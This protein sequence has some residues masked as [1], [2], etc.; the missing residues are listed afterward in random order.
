MKNIFIESVNSVIGLSDGQKGAVVSLYRTLFEDGAGHKPAYKKEEEKEDKKDDKKEEK[1]DDKKDD[2]KDGGKTDDA[3][4][5]WKRNRTPTNMTPVKK[6]DIKYIALHYTA[7]NSSS[8]GSACR[9]K[10]P[11]NCSADFIIDDSE[12]YQ[13]NPDLD[14]YFTWAVGV[15]DPQIKDK[16]VDEA[17]A[18][19][20]NDAASLYGN[21][22]NANTISIE[23]CS[24][25]NG[26]RPKNASPLDPNFY[27]TEATLGNTAKVV[28][29]LLSKYPG[30]K[31]IRHYDVTGKPCPGPWCRDE[32]GTQQYLSFV[33]RCNATPAPT[34][35]EYQDVDDSSFDKSQPS[36]PDFGRLFAPDK[37]KTTA[38]DAANATTENTLNAVI[39][40]VKTP[41]AKVLAGVISKINPNAS[42]NVV[43]EFA[44]MVASKPEL[45]KNVLKL[46]SNK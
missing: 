19:G 8:S 12:V 23:M 35:V 45:L 34:S 21:A 37:T 31:V 9:T 40:S 22:R 27:L 33:Q 42:P 11:A 1:K 46:V 5:E 43:A 32:K 4:A 41:A 2:K 15:S 28:A 25:Y 18:R 7:G 13:Y 26:E 36:W 24:N 29:Y 17:K 6:R 14:H 39:N 10:F 20:M 16:Y 30:A 44:N 3:P 38:G